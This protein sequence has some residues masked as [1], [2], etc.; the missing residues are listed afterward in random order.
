MK[1][2]QMVWIRK[3][4]FIKIILVFNGNQ[5]ITQSMCCLY[6]ENLTGNSSLHSLQFEYN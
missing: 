6:S 4:K 3:Y 2:L 1:L 5:L